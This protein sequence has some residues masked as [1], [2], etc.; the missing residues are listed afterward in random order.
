MQLAY[1]KFLSLTMADSDKRTPSWTD[2]IMY[3]TYTDSPD[4]PEESGITNLLYTSVPSYT[5]S[6]HVRGPVFPC[7]LLASYIL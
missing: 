5:T 2:R 3:A 6:D 7:P 1:T 4:N